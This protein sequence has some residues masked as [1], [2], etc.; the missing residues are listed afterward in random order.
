MT[1]RT[2]PLPESRIWNAK[3]VAAFLGH[4]EQW[5]YANRKTLELYKFP[6]RNVLMGGWDSQ[7]ITRWLD[8]KSDIAKPVFDTPDIQNR[9]LE[10]L[11]SYGQGC[12][13]IC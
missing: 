1:R 12:V 2:L 7:A 6:K 5:F 8:E 13:S 4:S 10:N 9:I 11:K 3:Q